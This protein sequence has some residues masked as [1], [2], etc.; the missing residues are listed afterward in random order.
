MTS[1]THGLLVWSG[2]GATVALAT[3]DGFRTVSNQTPPAVPT[4]GGLVVSVAGRRIAVGV[5]ASGALTVSP[6]EVGD[7]SRA[8]WTGGQLPGELSGWA[9]GVALDASTAWAVVA[10]GGPAA[11]GAA[12]SADSQ[13]VESADSGA[14]WKVAAQANVLDSSG[15]LTLTGVRWTDSTHGWLAGFGRAG[16]TVLFSSQS[17][18]SQWQPVQ[19][20]PPPGASAWAFEAASTPCGT[21]KDLVTLLVSQPATRASGQALIERSSDWGAHWSAGAP[22]PLAA[23]EPVW[24]CGAGSLWL[25]VHGPSAARLLVSTDAGATWRQG[26]TAPGALSALAVTGRGTGF[27][28]TGEGVKARLWAVSGGGARFA[29][30]PLPSW[31][32]KLS[33]DGES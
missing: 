31:V 3:G 17:D 1:G 14:S 33:A 25:A 22:V 21:G 24:A 2:D 18:A 11:S 4:D 9:D 20:A 32:D 10:H 26:G 19:L 23:G 16:S 6:F 8:G 12:V 27:A 5:R 30:I 15:E 13:L 28:V 29:P 7:G